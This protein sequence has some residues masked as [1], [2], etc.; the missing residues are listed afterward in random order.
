MRILFTGASSF[1]GYWFVKT[2]AA[3]GH[4]LVCPLTGGIERYVDVRRE[5]VRVLSSLS[6]LV[7]NTPFGGD[8]FLRLVCS[9]KFD[10][11]CHHGADVT[12]YKSADFDALSA[13]KN[14]TL[15]L[16]VVLKAL[17]CPVLVTGSVFENDEGSGDSPLRAFSPYG[18]SKGLT[19]QY[20]RYHCQDMGFPLGKFVIPNPFGPFEEPRFTAFLMK[21]WNA[22]QPVEVKTP[23]YLRDNIHVDLLALAYADFC[24]RVVST[25]LPLLKLHPCGYV[26]SQGEFAQRVAREVRTRTGLACEL[27]LA[28]QSDFSEPLS[29]FNTDSACVLFPEWS[30]TL[31]WDAFVKFYSQ[32]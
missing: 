13:L 31:A 26:E 10:L 14:N 17:N 24:E 5:R 15:N 19:F 9:E 16:R 25:R 27:K 11:I 8:D 20:F 1:T 6:R 23:D 3:A 4:E 21:S 32:G 18:L 22:G 7:P 12:N 28:Q 30:E 2:L 29:R